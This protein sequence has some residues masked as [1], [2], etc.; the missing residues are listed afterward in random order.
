V[1]LLVLDFE[2]YFDESYSLKKMT[3]EAYVRD[4]Q[5]KTHLVGYWLPEKM[6]S[7]A[8]CTDAIL[9]NNQSFRDLVSSSAVLCMHAH[10]DGLI[11]NHHYGLRPAF[12]FDILPM[13]RLVLPKLKSHSLEALAQ[14]FGLP[15]KSVPYNLFRGVRDLQSVPGLYEQVAEG[16]Q[17][18]VWL[19]HEIWKRLL[20]YVPQE[21]LKCIGVT[22]RM[23]CEPILELDHPRMEAFLQAEKIRKAKL[24]LE[25]GTG[26]GLPP[27]NLHDPEALR[28]HL[29]F[30]EEQMQSA[31]KFKQALSLFG[32]ACPMK[33]SE[34]QQCEIPALAKNDDGMQELLEHEDSRVQALAAARLGVK[35]T[36]DETRAE[37]LLDS[38]SRGPLPV[39]LSYAAAKTLRFGGGDKCL[40]ADTAVTVFDPQKG[41][42]Q[43]RIVD[44]LPDDLV[45]DG[46]DFV[47][48]DGVV[49]QGYQEV[50]EYDGVE[51][52][53]KH[54]VCKKGGGTISLAEAQR[55]GTKLLDCPAPT[56]RDVE[57]ARAWTS[58]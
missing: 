40:V 14:H 47:E 22:C 15:A 46:V 34:K 53:P 28:A 11:L 29:A 7:P 18:D 8:N 17:H 27:V 44:I 37:R 55:R 52:T 9:R 54:P 49:F 20:P 26:V 45:W 56:D 16:C 10:F 23:F 1:N 32:Y 35:S 36:I 3:T 58:Q 2:S 6:P 39:Y 13:A 57:R 51:G 4:P 50:I 42:T 41:L 5:F 24:L 43:K 48:H 19:T 12:W 21:E 31:E 33:W 25:V 30:V 38:G